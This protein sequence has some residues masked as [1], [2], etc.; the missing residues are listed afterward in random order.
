MWEAMKCKP[1]TEVGPAH[2]ES[3]REETYG[4]REAEEVYRGRK[5]GGETLSEGSTEKH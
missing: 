3:L 1:P 2:L 5:E 4:K